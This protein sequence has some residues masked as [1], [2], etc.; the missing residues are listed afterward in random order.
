[1]VKFFPMAKCLDVLL[2]DGD[3]VILEKT[4]ETLKVARYNVYPVSDF[5][6][7][8]RH[9]RSRK[10]RSV[11]VSELSVDGESVLNFMTKMMR[12]YPNVPFVLMASSPPLESVI[13]ALQWGAYDFLR[14]PVDPG[15]LCHSV[16]R[17]IE[18]LNLNIESEKHE[19]EAQDK[20]VR[21]QNE[22]KKVQLQNSFKGFL[23]SM[24][25]H[26]F[27]SI[28]TVLDGYN[29]ILKEKCSEC[30]R[31][32]QAESLE[33]SG[34]TIARLRIMANTLL[35]YEAAE[36]GEIHLEI[37]KCDI[38]EILKK[39][40]DFYKPYAAQK[41]IRLDSETDNCIVEAKGDPNR[42]MQILD[43]LLYNA[44]KFTPPDG[45]IHVGA[46]RGDDRSAV[47]W[48]ED[49]G[50]GIPKNQLAE[51]FK[52]RQNSSTG[53]V[54]KRVGLGLN[55][56]KKLIEIQHGKIWLESESGKGT[57]VFLSLPG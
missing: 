43:N 32:A 18:K 13:E 22:L 51:I 14:K 57:K 26:D 37:A 25:G 45:E 47:F 12:H 34:R 3:P 28:L 8:E 9:L 11:V 21:L 33:Q 2:I 31:P 24:A 36:R 7:A 23:I 53:N 4:S 15:I 40:V 52:E 48:V 19:K 16:A 55:I 29:Q 5:K 17:S 20:L 30:V 42:I 46:K 6:I 35:D 38:T 39:C 49:S 1:M 56:S 41:R 10:G 27:K 54:T 44:I 50:S